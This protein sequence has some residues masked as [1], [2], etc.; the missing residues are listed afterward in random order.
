MIAPGDLVVCRPWADETNPTPT[1]LFSHVV[2]MSEHPVVVGRMAPDQV[3]LVVAVVIA[4]ELVD[5]LVVHGG[6]AGWT[7]ASIL[8]KINVDPSRSR[9]PEPASDRRPSP[10][11][12]SARVPKRSR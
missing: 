2:G 11:L 9:V 10:S 12:W 7:L 1:S 8:S 3:G 4:K 5:C 6:V